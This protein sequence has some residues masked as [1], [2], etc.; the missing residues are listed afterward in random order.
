MEGYSSIEA[1]I[2]IEACIVTRAE[3]LDFGGSSE[4]L[5]VADCLYIKCNY[6][7]IS[8]L[9]ID[10]QNE[11]HL[12]NYAANDNSMSILAK[13]LLQT[14]LSRLYQTTKSYMPFNQLLQ[15]Y[16]SVSL[17]ALNR[18]WCPRAETFS[19]KRLTCP[20]DVD[21]AFEK[22]K[23]SK[24]SKLVVWDTQQTPGSS[25]SFRNNGVL[26]LHAD[27]KLLSSMLLSP[28]SL[29]RKAAQEF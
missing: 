13:S 6:L 7:S 11:E 14:E 26:L 29:L 23:L 10:L 24:A 8:D 19:E 16:G 12:L 25:Y 28:F 20:S 2:S 22:M 9:E 4:L 27:K 17:S 21:E 5:S 3:V 18:C 1:P 15:L